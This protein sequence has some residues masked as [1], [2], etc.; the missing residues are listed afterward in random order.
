MYIQHTKHVLCESDYI[1][2]NVYCCTVLAHVG[3]IYSL[4]EEMH[5]AVSDLQ[6]TVNVP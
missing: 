6:S 3:L 2:Y 5:E 1:I 4:E